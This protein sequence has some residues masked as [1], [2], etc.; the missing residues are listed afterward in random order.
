MNHRLK[1]AIAQC[2]TEATVE[3]K[4]AEIGDA[5]AKALAEA[6][7]ASTSMITFDLSWNNIS[8]EGAKAL[9][10]AIKASTSMTTLNLESNGIGDEGAKALAEAIKASTS[11]TTLNLR[12]NG[13]GDEGA[14]ALAEAVKGSTSMT[15]LNLESNG[16]GNEGVKALAEALPHCTSLSSLNLSCNLITDSGADA[17]VGVL[18]A[19][20]SG[21]ALNL[22]GNSIRGDVDSVVVGNVRVDGPLGSCIDFNRALLAMI[23]SS[24]GDFIDVLVGFG[25]L[26]RVCDALHDNLVE[27]SMCKC[28]SGDEPV[29]TLI[30][31]L[32]RCTALQKLTLANNAIG[33]AGTEALARSLPRW[34]ALESIDLRGN[35]ISCKGVKALA[36]ALPYCRVL[37][38]L[39]L[40]YN[41]IKDAGAQAL[42]DA[43]AL[44][45]NIETLSMSNNY[46]RSTGRCALTLWYMRSDCS[47]MYIDGF[48]SED[49]V[50]AVVALSPSKKYLER[51]RALTK[52]TGNASP[53]LKAL[54]DGWSMQERACV[55]LSV[56]PLWVFD[57][58]PG[59][60]AAYFRALGVAGED[61]VPRLLV[62]LI[63]AGGAGKTS[64]ARTLNHPKRLGRLTEPGPERATVGVER[65]GLLLGKDAARASLVLWDFGGQE[66]YEQSH[67]LF[68]PNGGVALIVV[69]LSAYRCNAA[70]FSQVRFYFEKIQAVTSGCRLLLVCTKADL[71]DPAEAEERR[72]DIV[73]RLEQLEKAARD[74]CALELAALTASEH[75][76]DP[77][78]VARRDELRRL[79]DNRAELEGGVVLSSAPC[80]ARGTSYGESTNAGVTELAHTLHDLA[81]KIGHRLPRLH[82]TLLDWLEARRSSLAVPVL[83]LAEMEAEWD[84]RNGFA[85]KGD[86]RAALQVL[87]DAGHVLWYARF[88]SRVFLDPAF[89]FDL[90]KQVARHDM[91]EN[92]EGRSPAE[93]R[94]AL[95]RFLGS[96]TPLPASQIEWAK[97]AYGQRGLLSVEHLTTR[98]DHWRDLKD[99]ESTRVA[100]ALVQMLGV[101]SV[102]TDEE[103]GAR[104]LFLPY[105][106]SHVAAATT[107][108]ALPPDVR[109]LAQRVWRFELFVPM[110]LVATLAARFS[111]LSPAAHH[112]QYSASV[113]C[114]VLRP[115]ASTEVRAS[116]EPAR[117]R[118]PC[119][120][121]LVV[122][123][124]DADA[125]EAHALMERFAAEVDA[126]LKGYPNMYGLSRWAVRPQGGRVNLVESGAGKP[127]GPSE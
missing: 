120:L 99:E 82:V 79:L 98:F 72:W 113:P 50:F 91:L 112:A 96:P 100:L 4:W 40:E 36:L 37:K 44:C 125:D 95:E 31:S 66:A 106:L 34:I 117:A 19:W 56:V 104:C 116:I 105:A 126:V 43:L 97:A 90:L 24:K 14:K 107:V 68:H 48:A 86:A 87:A 21:R 26:E 23:E 39:R 3:L 108:A 16:I 25:R 38:V 53:R 1:T 5:G 35:Q 41:V 9:A 123:G 77:P 121:W 78:V 89:L 94:G 6:A 73:D 84:E 110:G 63:G 92:A 42:A 45:V 71:I 18:P 81:L 55:Q 85:H 80:F 102:A 124:R 12:S 88:P 51:M 30:A 2:K 119:E 65:S 118:V 46:L 69:D 67:A 17:L 58:G 115:S 11:M 75:A 114:F 29:R 7:K 57:R 60:I 61:D 49:D 122:Y 111:A 32:A 33:D 93:R 20:V 59:D 76:D 127:R 70:S 28:L 62:S 10:E 15:T 83:D 8:K 22:K 54:I 47:R 27:F 74:C 13:I 103:T 101:A 64:I 109:P 52:H